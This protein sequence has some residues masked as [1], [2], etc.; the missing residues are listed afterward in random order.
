MEKCKQHKADRVSQCLQFGKPEDHQASTSSSKS[1]SRAAF[2]NVQ[3]E[4]Q[5]STEPQLSKSGL[6]RIQ[7]STSMAKLELIV[8]PNPETL[9]SIARSSVFLLEVA[10]SSSG[11]LVDAEP[12]ME[13]KISCPNCKVFCLS[14]DAPLSWPNLLLFRTLFCV[15]ALHTNTRDASQRNAVNQFRIADVKY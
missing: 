11:I 1:Q 3:R 8:P 12:K 9:L 10:N 6:E 15:F 4:P 5:A 13:Q 14:F 7:T 2:V